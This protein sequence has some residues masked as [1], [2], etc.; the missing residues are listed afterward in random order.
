MDVDNIAPGLDFVRELHERFEA[1]AGN[2]GPMFLG[3]LSITCA[4]VLMLI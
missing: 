2:A 4:F 1:A 3:F